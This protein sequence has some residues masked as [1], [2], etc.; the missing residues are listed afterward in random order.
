M[1]IAN[2][3]GTFMQVSRNALT[4]RNG[5]AAERH[6]CNR[7]EVKQR[8]ETYF[9]KAIST[10]ELVP[11]K[12]KSD[13]TVLFEDSSVVRI[14]NKEGGGNKHRGWSA[15]RRRVDLMP[16]SEAGKELLSIVCLKKE[17][18]RPSEVPVPSTLVRELLL[19]TEPD[20]MPAY[21]TH[22]KFDRDTGELLHLSIAPAETVVSAIKPYEFLTDKR[23]CVHIAPGMYLQRKGGGVSDSAPDDIQLKLV[24]FPD[25]VMMPLM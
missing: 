5:N 20:F 12:K 21:F 10:L 11:G 9:G 18:P 3:F 2:F 22:T 17:G 1:D 19:G 8:L 15:D 23:T 24:K 14:Q 4:A 16:V 13:V 7:P 6:L 25:G